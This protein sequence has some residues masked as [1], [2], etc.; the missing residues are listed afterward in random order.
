MAAVTVN[1]F[2]R[3]VAG[4]KEQ[5]FYDIDGSSGDT[6]SVP[7]TN[8]QK[9]NCTPSTVTAAVAAA[10][11]VIGFSTITFTSSGA[12]TNVQVEVLGQ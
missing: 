3:N 1:K 6:L 9:I 5:L 4:S 11:S 12:M 2:D 8:V 7:I 10:G